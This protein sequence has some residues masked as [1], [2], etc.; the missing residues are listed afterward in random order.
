M[1]ALGM[2]GE[3]DLRAYGQDL[4]LVAVAYL[5]GCFPAGYYWVRARTEQDVRASGSGS[6]GATNVARL[7]GGW[8]FLVTFVLD[9]AKGALAVALA[10]F[11]QAHHPTV[12]LALW[13]V[14]AG[15]IWPSHLG[16]RGGK[17]VATSLGALLVY[18]YRL[19]LVIGALGMIPFALLRSLTLAGLA[20]FVL[21]PFAVFLS[22]RFELVDVS[23]LSG[24]A[25]LILVAHRRNIRE[26][27]ARMWADSKARRA[28]RLAARD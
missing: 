25:V 8:G 22:H 12:A 14:T 15:H 1:V 10:R 20:G 4:C 3:I 19:L 21:A 11:G 18:D 2:G 27:V 24:L 5:L 28:K 17:G 26:E 23:A 13:A 9:C 7:L 16:F 6:A